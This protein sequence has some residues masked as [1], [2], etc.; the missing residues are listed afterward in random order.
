VPVH[1]VGPALER[2]VQSVLAQT[3]PAGELEAIFVDDGS[4][5]DSGAR[6][7]KLAAAYPHIR[8]LHIPASGS[9]GRPR[10]LALDQARGEYV[11]FLDADDRLASTATD[12]LYEMG[13]RNASDVVVGKL[14]SN[15]RSVS[16]DLFRRSREAC[17]FRDAPL[18]S[19]LTVCKLFRTAFLR[20]NGIRFPEGWPRIEDEYLVIRSY[21][22]AQGVSVYADEPVY[23]YCERDDGTNLSSQPLDPDQYYGHL[24]QILE[25]IRSSV[26]E[27]EVRAKLLRRFYRTEMLGRLSDAAFH[28]GD[29]AYRRR[30]FDA[31][32]ALAL[33]CMDDAVHD[34]LGAT[35]RLRSTLLREGRFEG[36]VTLVDRESALSLDATAGWPDVADGT[37]RVPFRT[38]IRWADQAPF[39]LERVGG[40]LFLDTRLTGGIAAAPI[41]V[42]DEVDGLRVQAA[43][44]ERGGW[45]E[46]MLPAGCQ[47]RLEGGG[48][49]KGLG[50]AV[51]GVTPVGTGTITVDPDAVGPAEI[52]LTTGTWDLVTRFRGLDLDL[53]ARVSAATRPPVSSAPI[54]M[55]G[56]LGVTMPEI[57]PGRPIALRVL[58]GAAGVAA[59]LPANARQHAGPRSRLEVFLPATA[60]RRTLAATSLVAGTNPAVHGHAARPRWGG[61]VVALERSELAVLGDGPQP[62]GLLVGD[63]PVVPLGTLALEGGR[64]SVAG[65]ARL[66]AASRLGLELRGGRTV[67]TRLVLRVV[68]WARRK[69]SGRS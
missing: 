55:G 60:D 18:V 67:T 58:G 36:L 61:V 8:V 68:R 57:A 6:L 40:R 32:R 44:V 41:D 34:G 37:L 62:M 59:W 45:G 2:S 31:M 25:L 52:T 39:V 48:E 19:N 3:M 14:V 51:N 17:S 50:H 43:L 22:A 28:A 1:D 16:W 47:V 38:A 66:G 9:P 27:G 29:E 30:L 4:T 63:G 42:T 12:R 21:L 7:D 35:L 33:D 13:S 10:N 53:R 11:F 5:D 24:R 49:G 46:W 56:T 20:D 64:H 65:M 26:E 54:L 69:V 15:F 23:Y